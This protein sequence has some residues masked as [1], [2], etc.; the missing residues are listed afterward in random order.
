MHE[1]LQPHDSGDSESVVLSHPMYDYRVE[2]H[3]DGCG[4]HMT[5]NAILIDCSR[6]TFD[7][8]YYAALFRHHSHAVEIVS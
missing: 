3:S 7:C 1:V 5:C 4:D 6:P 8:R 2:Y